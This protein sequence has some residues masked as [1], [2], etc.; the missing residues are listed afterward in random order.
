MRVKLTWLGPDGK[1]RA[2]IVSVPHVDKH[3][4]FCGIPLHTSSGELA[5]VRNLLLY[6]RN[7]YVFEDGDGMFAIR[8]ANTISIEPL[9]ETSES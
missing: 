3:L 2:E 9:P 5:T 7:H 1:I 6:L 4:S 8:V